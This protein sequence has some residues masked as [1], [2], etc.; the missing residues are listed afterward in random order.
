MTITLLTPAGG[1]ALPFQ[2]GETLL[3]ALRRGAVDFPA[4]CGGRGICG[5]CTVY[6][7]AGER[8]T[9]VLACR[10]PAEDGMLLRVPEASPLAVAVAGVE[11]ARPLTE[12][13]AGAGWGIAWDIGT[14]TVVGALVELSTGRT[15]ATAGEANAQRSYGGDVISRIKAAMDG[16]L[17][18]LTAA[19][20]SQMARMALGLC[21]QAGVAPNAVRCMAVAGNTTMCHLLT[22]LNPAGLGAAPFTPRSLFGTEYDARALELP[23]DAAVFICPAVSGYVG[24]DIT[25]DL[26]WTAPDTAKAPVLLIDVGTNGEMA[27]GC[28]GRFLCCSTAA[29]PAFEGAQ[30][31]CGMTAAPGAVSAVELRDGALHCTVLGGGTA[32]GICGSGL[33]DAVAVMLHLG[34]VDETG[35]MLDAKEGAGE[36][37]DAARQ[38]LFT[39]PDGE[40]AFRLTGDVYVTQGD[41]RRLQLGK[42]AIAAGLQVLLSAYGI[43]CAQVGELL[44]AGGFGSFLRPESAAR[45]GLIPAELLSVTRSVGNAAAEGAKA[46]MLSAAARARIGALR[47]SMEYIELSGLAAFNE[48]YMEAM[49]FPEEDT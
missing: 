11:P 13:G 25:A 36:I 5:K 24:G 40:R 41:V 48:A 6:L 35:R 8:E 46:A 16:A 33:L 3:E 32:A 9:P 21:T 29:G 42:G 10:T 30:I 19:L 43:S 1:R 31:A 44:L 23:F 26:L 47:D 15:A 12:A 18:A 49:F 2:P 37:P 28:G 22:G 45:I 7:C 34:A 38:Y 17:P 20:R 4:P 27:L 14:T 39:L